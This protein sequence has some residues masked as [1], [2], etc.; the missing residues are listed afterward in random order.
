MKTSLLTSIVLIVVVW[1]SFFV[2]VGA[3]ARAAKELFCI[4]FG[5]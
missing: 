1:M 5:C 2:A 3:M 4:G